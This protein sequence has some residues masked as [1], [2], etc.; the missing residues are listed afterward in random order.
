MKRALIIDCCIRRDQSRTR[1]ILDAFRAGLDPAVCQQQYLCLMDADLKPLT[2]DFF[3]ERQRLLEENRL[4]HP[5]FRY[6]HQFAD[7]DL[8]VIAAPF[9]DLSFPA[10]LKIYVENVSV[11]GI[12]FR[13]TAD[14][15]QGLCRADSMVY[16]T[17]RGG[18][19]PTGSAQEQAT[20]YLSALC[21]FFGIGGMEC[22]GA[23]GMDIAGYNAGFSLQKACDTAAG[24][25]AELSRDGR[26]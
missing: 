7:A 12:T 13:A 17:S 19:V 26:K 4:E 20:P 10:L 23:D 14:G 6:A 2:G 21:T 9:Y 16:L 3:E 11:D 18:I 8:I 5:R 15:I 25:A 24:K 1:R 22:I